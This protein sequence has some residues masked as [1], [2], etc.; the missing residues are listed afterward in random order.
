MHLRAGDTTVSCSSTNIAFQ[1]NLASIFDIIRPKQKTDDPSY[2]LEFISKLGM[3]ASPT[4]M[5]AGG[6]AVKLLSG[7]CRFMR[8]HVYI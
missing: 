7:V 1:D 2:K 3:I 5:K 4:P 8:A 6:A